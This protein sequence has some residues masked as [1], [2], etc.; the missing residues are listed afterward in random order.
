LPALAYFVDLD[1]FQQNK[2]ITNLTAVAGE[3]ALLQLPIE[4]RLAAGVFC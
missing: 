1:L 2:C 3:A 4:R